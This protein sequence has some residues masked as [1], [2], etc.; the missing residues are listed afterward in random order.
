MIKKMRLEKGWSQEDLANFS[1]LS[2]RSIQRIEK[3]SKASVETLKSLAA[4]FEVDF[5]QLKQEQQMN[6][7]DKLTQ[8]EKEMLEEIKEQKDFYIHA[9]N[10]AVV[11]TGLFIINYFVLGGY[12]W[13]WWVF[14]GW[15]IGITTHALG[16]FGWH[17]IFLKDWEKKQLEKKLGRKL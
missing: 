3:G 15:G 4:V 10:F 14:F 8:E 11:M 13:V 17:G 9:V 12:K 5:N 2:V 16:V 1:G 6:Y 7:V